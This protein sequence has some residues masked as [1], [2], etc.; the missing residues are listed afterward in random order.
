[1]SGAHGIGIPRTA[2]RT[3]EGSV[4]MWVCCNETAG[5]QIC[6]AEKGLPTQTRVFGLAGAPRHDSKLDGAFSGFRNGTE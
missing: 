5:L 1:M 6:S 3:E 4:A 2:G